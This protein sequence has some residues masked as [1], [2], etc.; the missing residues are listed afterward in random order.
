MRAQTGGRPPTNDDIA[1]S[2]S[3]PCL[4]WNLAERLS[5]VAGDRWLLG[6]DERLGHGGWNRTQL[7][8]FLQ[9]RAK[10]RRGARKKRGF[11]NVTTYPSFNKIF[12]RQLFDQTFQLN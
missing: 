6:N 3:G 2:R 7:R 8:R 11:W 9:A 4:F 5:D 10:F 1:R 12:S